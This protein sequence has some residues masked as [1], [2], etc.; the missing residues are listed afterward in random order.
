MDGDDQ[1]QRQKQGVV[2]LLCFFVMPQNVSRFFRMSAA[3]FARPIDSND[4]QS[5]VSQYI[6]I[7]H[8]YPLKVALSA[9]SYALSRVSSR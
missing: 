2:T 9:M 3:S 5:R 6:L 1:E 7:P 4:F 8:R